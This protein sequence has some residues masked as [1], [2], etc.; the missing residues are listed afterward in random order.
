MTTLIIEVSQEDLEW[1]LEHA[2]QDNDYFTLEDID[3]FHRVI[4]AIENAK[5]IGDRK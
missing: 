5:E 3:R 2:G 4:E 1:F